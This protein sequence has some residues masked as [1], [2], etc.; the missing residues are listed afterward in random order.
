MISH[1]GRGVTFCQNPGTR[2]PR[3]PL[4]HPGME[5]PG[6]AT[7]HPP[8]YYLVQNIQEIHF[9]TTR[10]FSQLTTHDAQVPG[11][12]AVRR[13]PGHLPH[14]AKY[15]RVVQERVPQ[16][17]RVRSGG[18]P[19]IVHIIPRCDIN[20]AAGADAAQWSNHL[21]QKQLDFKTLCNVTLSFVRTWYEKVAA[22]RAYNRRYRYAGTSSCWRLVC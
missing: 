15:S 9:K 5:T 16:V 13:I 11:Y 20:E 12:T 21:T 3:Y 22:V 17:R 10:S 19:L 4:Y 1:S 6:M 8:E 14:T 18:A 2:V 7:Y